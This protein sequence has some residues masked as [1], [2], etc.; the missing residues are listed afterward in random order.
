MMV[1]GLEQTQEV[2]NIRKS[3]SE[4]EQ[5]EVCSSDAENNNNKNQNQNNN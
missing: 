3:L 2:L 1:Q 5:N 4:I